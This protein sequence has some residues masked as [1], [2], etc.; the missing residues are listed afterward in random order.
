MPEI[1][2]GMGEDYG[3][4][5]FC[6]IRNIAFYAVANMWSGITQMPHFNISASLSRR[7]TSRVAKE[8]R[9]K[10]HGRPEWVQQI[11]IKGRW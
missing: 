6:P 10:K 8:W 11:R 4:G 9:K 3:M 7:I 1:R 2:M 5:A